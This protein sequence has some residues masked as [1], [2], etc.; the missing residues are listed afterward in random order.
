MSS[1]PF[2]LSSAVGAALCL[3]AL[4]IT[5]LSCSDAG[6]RGFGDAAD[7]PITLA[8]PGQVPTRQVFTATL[9]PQNRSGVTGR[10]RFVIEGDQL[11]VIVEATGFDPGMMHM[12]HL[13]AGPNC[14]DESADRNSDSYVDA[15]E[16]ETVS[17]KPVLA[18]SL[19]DELGAEDTTAALQA[20]YPV[21][22]ENGTVLYIRS[23]PVEKLRALLF[24]TA[25]ASASPG[26]SGIPSPSASPSFFP[27]PFPSASASPGPAQADLPLEQ[28]VIEFHGI[29]LE[30][31]LPGTV[32]SM[33][34]I[35]SNASLPVAC[36]RIERAE[37]NQPTDPLEPIER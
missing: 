36:A 14:P 19:S 6:T 28:L 29:D 26:P 37:E 11:G 3:S 1:N 17:G 9:E 7:G 27:S 22:D 18:L 34:G 33:D 5:G 4:G 12:Q 20:R 2:L 24:P 32:A 16:A 15:Q 30:E 25:S 23:L 31:T 8:Q 13:H 10:A 21:P 35:P